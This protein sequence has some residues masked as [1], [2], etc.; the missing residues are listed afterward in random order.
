MVEFATNVDIGNRALQH[1]GDLRISSFTEPSRQAREIA[2]AY[3]KL[4]QSELRR[5]LWRFATR[6]AVLRPLDTTTLQLFP[7]AWSAA[8]LYVMGSVVSYN[9][10]LYEC[11]DWLVTGS[12][13]D[14]G[15]PWVPYFGPI[16]VSLYT[17]G[18]SYWPGELIYTPQTEGYVVY[19]ALAATTDTPGSFPNWSSAVAYNRGQS[20]GS[21]G[22]QLEFTPGNALVFFNPGNLAV[23]A[24][25]GSQVQS[26]RDLNLGNDP[27]VAQA[28]NWQAVPAT[29]QPHYNTGLNWL[30]LSDA[31]LKSIVT[32]YPLTAGPCSDPHTLN[33]YRLPNGHF[34]RAPADPKGGVIP[35]LGGPSNPVPTDIVE[36]NGYLVTAQGNAFM[37]RFVADVIDV[38]S[39]DPMFAEGLSLR[40]AIDVGPAVIEKDVRAQTMARIR[41][42][43]KEVMGE[44]RLLDAIERGETTVPLDPYVAVRV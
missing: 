29:N 5:N 8:S 43:Y 36:E 3:D 31:T 32:P 2:F 41:D 15:V 20:I 11:T 23:N 42:R 9:G 16:T 13:P 12:V 22:G 35:P 33:A 30:R 44:A 34:R 25:A 6:R 26:L 4:R 17:S 19:V 14:A 27:S 37:Y 10:A 40:I 39:M 38:P 1:C 28:P 21:G 24:Q 18:T 7:G